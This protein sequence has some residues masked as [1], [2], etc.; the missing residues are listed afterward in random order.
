MKEVKFVPECA[1]GKGATF[2]GHLVLVKPTVQ[3]VLAG[4]KLAQ[5]IKEGQELDAVQG[6][7]D[8]SKT[9]YKE[10]ELENTC[11]GSK[12][13]SF[14]DL[15]GDAECMEVLNEVALKLVTGLTRKKPM[16]VD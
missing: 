11:D 12:Y 5:G 6:F 4:S 15:M 9:F 16:K 3:D 7:L 10:V 14:D 13:V 8:W 2:K 1:T